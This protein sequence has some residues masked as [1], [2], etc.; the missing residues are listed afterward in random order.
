MHRG[1]VLTYLVSPAPREVMHLSGRSFLK[2]TIGQFFN[3]PIIFFGKL[4]LVLVAG[5]K[6]K[7]HAS[8]PQCN[9]PADD[10]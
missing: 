2:K 6:L 3:I 1:L 10:T 5:V 9:Y 8:I 7:T 4:R